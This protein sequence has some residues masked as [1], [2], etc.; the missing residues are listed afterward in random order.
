MQKVMRR[1]RVP[2]EQIAV[3]NAGADYHLSFSVKTAA[4]LILL[5]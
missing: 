5:A 2:G 4:P 1:T 3:Q